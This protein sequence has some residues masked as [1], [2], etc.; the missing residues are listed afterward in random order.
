MSSLQ[1]VLFSEVDETDFAYVE[2]LTDAVLAVVGAAT[3]QE[4]KE[5]VSE[6]LCVTLVAACAA[7]V[8][9][10]EVLHEADGLE[11]FVEALFVAG[12]VDVP[13]LDTLL[14][15]VV[16]CSCSFF[17]LVRG[18]CCAPCGT[19]LSAGLVCFSGLL[20]G[21]SLVS[22]TRTQRKERIYQDRESYR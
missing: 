6:H 12:T 18:E 16:A 8:L 19:W 3:L 20:T 9:A 10:H 21:L 5:M 14:R 17:F 1:C 2:G 4:E 22:E 7:E 11:Q 13:S 15:W